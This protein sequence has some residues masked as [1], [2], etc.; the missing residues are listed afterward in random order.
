LAANTLGSGM[1]ISIRFSI[2]SL[3]LTLLVGVSLFIV[4]V[5]YFTLDTILI[6]TTEDT[7]DHAAGM[8]GEQVARYLQPL[9]RFSYIGANLIS[10]NVITPAPSKNFVHFL[11]SI[12]SDE[13]EIAATFWADEHGNFYLLK[14]SENNHLTNINIIIDPH[15]T[16]SI[17][18]IYD[19]N[20]V[21][22]GSKET[23][24]ASFDPRLRPWYQ[25][26][27]F[28]KHPAWFV[29]PLVLTGS[30]KNELGITAVYP[31]YDK[32]K[33]LRGV[34]G[35]DIPLGTV[36]T[37]VKNIKITK[38]SVVFVCDA[39]GHLITAYSAASTNLLE[40]YKMPRLANLKMPWVEQ[41]FDLYRQTE[42]PTFIYTHNNKKYIAAYEK[43]PD[44]KSDSEWTIGIVTPFKDVVAPLQRGIFLSFIFVFI[45]LG[46]GIAFSAF[47]SSRISKPIIKLAKDAE[48]IC[49]LKLGEITQTFSRI[50]E[51]AYMADT[52]IKMKGALNSFQRYMPIALVKNLISTGKVAEVGGET[53]E[54][55]LLF[56][57]IE[58]FTAT[59]ENMAPQQVMLY[60]SEYFQAITKVIINTHGTVDK[61]IGDGAMAFWGAPIEDPQHAIHACQAAVQIKKAFA[62]LNEKWKS[63]GIPQTATRIG[64]NTGSV[65]VGNVGSDDRLSYTALGDDVNLA[66]RLESLNKAYGIYTLVGEGTYKTA[67]DHFK[68]RL[69]D[70]VAVKGKKH[71]VYVYELLGENTA[72]PDLQLEQYNNMFQEAFTLYE[73]GE[74]EKAQALFSKLANSKPQ[75]HLLQIFIERCQTFY[76]QPPKNW[77][78]TWTMTHK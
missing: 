7:I 44:I 52:F 54:L 47:F 19:S 41:S 15:N 37:F 20:M 48:L 17:E 28:K 49:Q 32:S 33:K 4:S 73:H 66:S 11:H 29:Y 14:E 36:S 78:G 65:I 69:I 42:D 60:L 16:R 30:K 74:W 45:A 70:R 31:I 10:D 62:E 2:L 63:E 68:F 58:S 67:K 1:K 76:K 12:I 40:G 46:I 50:K 24:G 35:I 8:V 5:N 72:T 71:G 75:D 23:A 3:L 38:N 61:Y 34:F 53:K 64:I 55:T 59:S 77:T 39:R 27:R 57:D 25:Q 13:T 18:N 56:S 22:L 6:K 26:A 43:I 21:L 9:N 51:I